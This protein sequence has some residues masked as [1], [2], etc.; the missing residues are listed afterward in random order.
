LAEQNHGQKNQSPC[1]LG[2]AD[3]GCLYLKVDKSGAKRWTFMYVRDGKQREAG[4]G[5]VNSI[6]IRKAREIAA[7]MRESLALR[8]LTHFK[9][10]NPNASPALHE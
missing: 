8:R 10:D 4:L 1:R 5:P 9:R 7:G 6:G 2:H 3:G